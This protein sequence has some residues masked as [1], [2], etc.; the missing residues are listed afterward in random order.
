MAN[1]P[2]QRQD[3]IDALSALIAELK[4]TKTKATFRIVGGAALAI[5]YFDRPATTDVDSMSLKGCSESKSSC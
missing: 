3:I 2:M 1:T 4:A 5:Q